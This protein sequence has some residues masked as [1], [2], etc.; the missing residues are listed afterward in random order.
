MDIGKNCKI[1]N[2][3]DFLPFYCKKCH[4]N[5]CKEHYISLQH[6]N[7]CFKKNTNIADHKKKIIIND[8]CIECGR[9]LYTTKCP[10]CNSYVCMT[11]RFIDQHNCSYHRSREGEFLKKK[12]I[13]GIKKKK[14]E[15]SC[16]CIS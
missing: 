2:R 9:G 15:N 1:C 6:D 13:I 4:Y 5:F 10:D 8:R 16:C 14:K 12:E 3:I 7:I 11:H